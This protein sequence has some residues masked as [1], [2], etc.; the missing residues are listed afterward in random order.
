MCEFFLLEI[1]YCSDTVNSHTTGVVIRITGFCKHSLHYALLHDLCPHTNPT[2][3]LLLS[4]L[5]RR[6]L[7]RR[8]AAK[9]G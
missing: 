8:E 2:R 5:R 4:F 6:K 9:R 1:D 3:E 7:R